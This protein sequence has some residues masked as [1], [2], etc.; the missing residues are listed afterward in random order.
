VRAIPLDAQSFWMDE[1]Y[2]VFFIDRPFLDA[3]RTIIQPHHNGPL[4]YLLLFFW[5]RL[6]GPSDFAV[7]YLSLFFS[8][9]GVALL[10][11]LMA[12]RLNPSI[13]VT[14]AGLF[15]VLPFAIWYGQEAKMYALHMAIS[16]ASWMALWAAF[17]RGGLWRW[18]AYALLASA[19]AYS[20][21][22]GVFTLIAQGCAALV[23]GWRRRRALLGYLST[24]GLMALIYAPAIMF[25]IRVWDSYVPRDPW[26]RYYPWTEMA[27]DLLAQFAL[28]LSPPLVP[29]PFQ[30]GIA[31]GIL[32]GL[33]GLLRRHPRAG[34]PFAIA[35]LIPPTVFWLV[36]RRLPVYS[37]K[38]LSAT[39]P[40]FVAF[41][42]AAL[43]LLPHRIA[44]GVLGL[45][46]AGLTLWASLR[47]NSDPGLLRE[48]WR[49]VAGYLEAMGRPGDIIVV[50]VDYA[51]VPLL[52]YY[53]G[54]APVIRFGGDP[55]HPM[56]FF[57]E[58]G[59]QAARIWLVLAHADVMAPGNRLK[60]EL[61]ASY[62]LITEQYPSGGRLVVVGV[63]RNPVHSHLPPPAE[64]VRVAFGNG[65]RVVGYEIDS[66]AFPARDRRLHPPSHWIHLTLY[67]QREAATAP[68][69]G[70]WRVR[71]WMLDALGQIWGGPLERGQQALEGYPPD[72]W[73]PGEIVETHVEININPRTP[74]GEY[75]IAITLEDEA[76][77]R[78]PAAD[79]EA[80]VPLRTV[81]VLPP[82][83]WEPEGKAHRTR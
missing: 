44:R 17:E 67:L 29:W 26:R 73:G 30:V 66:A 4:Y 11:R 58:V 50:Y 16:L 47:L 63:Q 25:L 75:R 8:V 81:R 71:A 57:E 54:P 24:I 68:V 53:R 60:E 40:F 42:A 45:G 41:L 59:R 31:I 69:N 18:S 23:W 33:I 51:H 39:F 72:R 49:W 20:H 62:P 48:D 77:Q 6:A 27:Q 55:Y 36:S 2:A 83:M 38:Y 1:A 80:V 37:A 34:L 12:K 9:L 15:S 76:G 5:Y 35:L 14:G 3:L 13:A 78:V 46:L 22:F 43:H 64:P 7:R 70:R 79:G 28:Q 65:I 61:K 52:R 21:F 19:L 82:A 10:Y 32:V 74:P 56:P